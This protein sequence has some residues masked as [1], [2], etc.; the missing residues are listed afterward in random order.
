MQNGDGG[1]LGRQRGEGRRGHWGMATVRYQRN[2]AERWW[3]VFLWLPVGVLVVRFLTGIALVVQPYV[4]ESVVVLTETPPP[5]ARPSEELKLRG[6]LLERVAFGLDL[7]A[8][9]GMSEEEVLALLREQVSIRRT[10]DGKYTEIVVRS[11]VAGDARDMASFLG[12]VYE[13]WHRMEVL[14][15]RSVEEVK[16]MRLRDFLAERRQHDAANV[17]AWAEAA[18]RDEV[19]RLAMKVVEEGL[20]ESEAVRLLDAER[21]GGAGIRPDG[22]DLVPAIDPAEEEERA[23]ARAAEIRDYREFKDRMAEVEAELA[24][25]KESGVGAGIPAPA[26]VG[27]MVEA[28][29]GRFPV[30]PRTALWMTVAIYPGVALGFLLWHLY[31]S[32]WRDPEKSAVRAARKDEERRSCEY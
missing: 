17:E 15:T 23:V 18:A 11:T 20:E 16:G 6:P 28:E 25:L 5:P 31:L 13:G 12:H 9:W 10:G 7:A 24:K 8:R 22:I 3:T 14:E 1:L 21:K 27:I 26:A 19:T 32:R 29:V 2:L 30:S 4:Y